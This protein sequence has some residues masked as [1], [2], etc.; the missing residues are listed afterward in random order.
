MRLPQICLETNLG[1]ECGGAGRGGGGGGGGG[2]GGGGWEDGMWLGE[3]AGG[4]RW[5]MGS[6]KVGV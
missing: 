1:L 2:C 5:R 4:G 6:I 3:R